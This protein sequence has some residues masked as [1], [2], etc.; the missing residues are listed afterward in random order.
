MQ[1]DTRTGPPTYADVSKAA[2]VYARAAPATGPHAT[3]HVD[4]KPNDAILFD[5]LANWAPGEAIRNRILV[6][7]PVAPYGFDWKRAQGQIYPPL[8]LKQ[9][10]DSGKSV[11]GNQ[12]TALGKKIAK[13][14]VTKKIT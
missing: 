5:L 2:Q 10:T 11:F 6:N 9:P 3:E 8:T 1:R 13:A 7:N 4:A 14:I 12:S